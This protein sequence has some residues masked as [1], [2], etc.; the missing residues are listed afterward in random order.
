MHESYLNVSSGSRAGDSNF[1]AGVTLTQAADKNKKSK[2]WKSTEK[3]IN[4]G[5][6]PSGPGTRPATEPAPK[7]GN[8]QP[9]RSS[10]WTSHLLRSRQ[11]RR[12]GSGHRFNPGPSEKNSLRGPAGGPPTDPKRVWRRPHPR[13]VS[14]KVRETAGWRA[15]PEDQ[16][17]GR[18]REGDELEPDGR[19]MRQLTILVTEKKRVEIARP[20]GAK[21]ITDV[22]YDRTAG[23]ARETI[24]TDARGTPVRRQLW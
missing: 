16:R 2:V 11:R 23:R 9:L 8:A 5:T 10:N 19:S 3:A 18:I 21:E 15:C 24:K 1:L 4:S 14:R 7:L 20:N 13:E 22:H 6:Q 12:F 17:G